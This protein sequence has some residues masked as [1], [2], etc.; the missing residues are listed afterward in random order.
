VGPAGAQGLVGPAG[1]AGAQGPTGPLGDQGLVGPVGP[2]GPAGAQGPAGITNQETLLSDIQRIIR[3]ETFAAR[4]KASV[5]HED[6]SCDS[7]CM[8]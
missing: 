4:Q 1:P 7:D 2:A 8:S 5:E 3:N 6:S